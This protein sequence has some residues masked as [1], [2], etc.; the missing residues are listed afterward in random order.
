[1]SDCAWKC[2]MGV[3]FYVGKQW[4]CPVCGTVYKGTEDMGVE[5]IDNV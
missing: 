5:V 4:T 2:P 1:M 3:T